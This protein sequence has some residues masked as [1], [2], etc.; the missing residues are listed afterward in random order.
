MTTKLF[1]AVCL[2]LLAPAL[3]VKH[4]LQVDLRGSATAL[5]HGNAHVEFEQWPQSAGHWLL[6]M[7]MIIGMCCCCCCLWTCCLLCCGPGLG[8]YLVSSHIRDQ[9]EREATPEDRR[10][11]DSEEFRE[12]VRDIFK[13]V[14]P[15]GLLS[16]KAMKDGALPGS[17]GMEPQF[18][19]MAFD[20]N[21]D[22]YLDEEE[23]FYLWR[24]IKFNQHK[25]LG[26]EMSSQ[27][28]AAGPSAVTG[29]DEQVL[30]AAMAKREVL[31]LAQAGPE[32]RSLE[33]ERITK[34][35]VSDKTPEKQKQ[36]NALV[37][38]EIQKLREWRL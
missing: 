2:H 12:E 27:R 19:L 1:S 9:F 11:F 3:G 16:E 26:S 22:G 10:K 18:L 32:R 36:W 15:S 5:H 8:K 35:W 38:Q 6:L 14:A 21:E 24:T 17:I 4:V 30:A 28:A 34:R 7:L 37:Y 29:A 31:F 23:F 13:N 20:T 25:S 33:K